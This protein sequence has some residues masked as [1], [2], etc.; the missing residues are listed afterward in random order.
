MHQ[1]MMS[2]RSKEATVY[3]THAER[4]NS[5]NL[6]R[7]PSSWLTESKLCAYGSPARDQSA[8]DDDSA[9][10]P[11]TL[12]RHADGPDIA[13]D[14]AAGCSGGSGLHVDDIRPRGAGNGHGHGSG[15]FHLSV[16]TRCGMFVFGERWLWW[17]Q[18]L[19]RSLCGKLWRFGRL[20]LWT[21][22]WGFAGYHR[23][24]LDVLIVFC[25]GERR[26]VWAH[27]GEYYGRDM[28]IAA[29]ETQN[30]G[31]WWLNGF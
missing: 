25:W 24:E 10:S 1:Q 5:H 8:Y 27:G 3:A 16:W 11:S 15:G 4:H 28:R 7:A 29:V 26:V 23:K 31:S 19:R 30:G 20:G 13:A 17:L 6:E 18:N 12:D 14:L 2:S 21:V 22:F 9:C